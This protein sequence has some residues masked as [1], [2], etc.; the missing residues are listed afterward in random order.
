MARIV[1]KATYK[2]KMIKQEDLPRLRHIDSSFIIKSAEVIATGAF[3]DGTLFQDI[4][5]VIKQGVIGS[6]EESNQ[7]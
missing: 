6:E 3:D 5:V 1:A 4:R 2:N 7:D